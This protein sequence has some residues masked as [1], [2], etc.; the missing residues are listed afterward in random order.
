MRFVK[1]V[2]ACALVLLLASAP[3]R[4]SSATSEITDM[5]WN[6]AESGWGVNV[7][8]QSNVAFLTFFVYDATRTPI[9]YTSDAYLGDNFAWTGKLYQTSGPWF[10][11]PFPPANV[12]VRQVGTV[13]FAVTGL[14]QATLTYTVDGVTV[15]KTVERQT[16]ANEN[17]TG[18]YLGGYSFRDVN[19]NPSSLNG[20][21]EAGGLMTVT[22]NGSSLTIA[23]A[24]AGGSCTF[25][26][27]Y[28]Q[29]GKLGQVSGNFSCATGAQGP[30]T[31]FEMT[32]TVSGF[33]GRLVGTSQFC[34]F[35]GYL[36]GVARSQ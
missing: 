13:S 5:W 26:G 25:A 34:Q 14:N 33:T 12:T 6:P 30:F 4:A 7:I 27:N 18:N 20:I 2:Q 36:G 29:T 23:L 9:W 15:T 3:A 22:Q 10:G 35:S 32:P 17:Y 21:E 16:W 19:C 11:G 8:L 31:M 24:T 28:S 1:Y